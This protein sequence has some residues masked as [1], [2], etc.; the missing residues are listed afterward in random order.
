[1]NVYLSFQQNWWVWSNKNP[2]EAS[3]CFHSKSLIWAIASRLVYFLFLNKISQNTCDFQTVLATELYY[4]TKFYPPTAQIQQQR[5][6]S[7]FSKSWG[8]IHV[9]EAKCSTCRLAISHQAVQ[10]SISWTTTTA[11]SRLYIS[12]WQLHTAN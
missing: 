7:C 1:M 8:E 12:E 2:S 4:H 10:D 6:H 9:P 11:Q 5:M 3:L